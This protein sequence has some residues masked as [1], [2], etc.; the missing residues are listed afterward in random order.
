MPFIILCGFPCSGK[1][2]RS[3]EL[4]EYFEKTKRLRTVI[5][6]EHDRELQ[7]NFLYSGII[8]FLIIERKWLRAGLPCTHWP[9]V[10][11]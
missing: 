8:W 11:S 1:T 5:I 9:E 6:S 2:S 3:L 10:N 7:R 4:K